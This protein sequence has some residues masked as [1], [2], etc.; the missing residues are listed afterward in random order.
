L[1]AKIAQIES[2]GQL[3]GVARASNCSG[4]RFLL[5]A[6]SAQSETLDDNKY[7]FDTVDTTSGVTLHTL[8]DDGST[9]EA[10]LFAPRVG[11]A[12][13]FMYIISRQAK[14]TPLRRSKQPCAVAVSILVHSQGSVTQARFD[15][16]LNTDKFYTYVGDVVIGGDGSV[17]FFHPSPEGTAYLDDQIAHTA[18]EAAPQDTPPSPAAPAASDRAPRDPSGRRQPESR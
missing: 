11:G 5:G 17:D 18:V 6:L 8:R 7:L 4:E 12:R 16:L 2:L 3:A 15:V 10:T 14:G 9:A 1:K 13:Y